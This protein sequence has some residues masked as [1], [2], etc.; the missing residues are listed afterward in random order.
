MKNK[1]IALLFTFLLLVPLSV[2]A[3]SAESYVVMDAQTGE[4]LLC[5]NENRRLTMAS[6]TKIMTALV[7]LES[8]DLYKEYTVPD[9]AVGI[10]GSSI[11]LKKGE[12]LTGIELLKG[13]MLASGNDAA[14][15]IA[16]LSAGS[17]DAFIMKMNLRAR[18]MGLTETYFS[19]P[20]GLE[21]KNHY[22]TAKELAIISINALRHPLFKKIVSLK[23]DSITG[24]TLF[25]KNKILTITSG[26][27]G[28]KTG[29]TKA[30]GR[31][32]VASA[33][34]QGRTL[35]CVVLNAPDWFNDADTLL[36]KG[37]KK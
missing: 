22:T 18:E 28:V 5:K 24:R 32:L 15:A 34:R 20:S 7:A 21:S 33:T 10:E 3:E 6:T 4:I 36:E 25:N 35:V 14:M 16:I 13:L 23:A 11:Y 2:N 12:K 8:L 19:C 27:D 9:E 37:F 29:Y 26:G 17:R 1:I 31:C 30:A